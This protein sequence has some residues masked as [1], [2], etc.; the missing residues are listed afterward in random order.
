MAPQ[1]SVHSSAPSTHAPPRTLCLLFDGTSNE[2]DETVRHSPLL[3]TRFLQQTLTPTLIAEYECR[4]SLRLV[5]ESFRS[6]KSMTLTK[7]DWKKMDDM[8]K[9]MVFY[10]VSSS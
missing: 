10:Q 3:R 9:Q 2:F 8:G 1:P 4:P 6:L 5:G 7:C